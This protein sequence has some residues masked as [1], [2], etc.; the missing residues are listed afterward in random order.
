[1]PASLSSFISGNNY[2]R[3]AI[4]GTFVAGMKVGTGYVAPTFTNT[5]ASNNP[6][7]LFGWLIYAR[8]NTAYYNPAK[9]TTAD[10][11]ILYS[12][13][14]D[15]VGDLNKLSGITNCL[16]LDSTTAS[17][18]T[19]FFINTDSSTVTA[20]QNGIDFLYALNYL[21]YGGQL[22]LAP[23]VTGFDT[24]QSNTGTY[25][26]VVIDKDID[27][28]VANWL[29]TQ[30]YTI[31]IYPTVAVAGV[32]GEGLTL[33]SFDSAPISWS[34][35]DITGNAGKRI[36]GVYGTKT[37]STSDENFDISSL[38]SNGKF[39][40]TLNTT[41]DVAGFFARAKGRNE[42]Y[43]T[44]AGMDRSMPLNGSINNTVDWSSTTRTELK[45]KRVNFFVN[46][47]PRFLGSDLV[48]ATLNTSIT[49]NDRVGPARMRSALTNKLNEIGLKYSFEINNAS[50]R[51]AVNSEIQTALEQ[52]SSYIDTTRT[53]IICDSSNNTDNSSELKISVIVKPLLSVDSFVIDLTFTQ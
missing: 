19:G 17:G 45:T 47:S 31:G 3:E 7:G 11:Y 40:Y 27:S 26:D 36:F 38:L 41:A 49:V 8:S 39:A 22:L 33:P 37:K 2:T 5:G 18:N 21:A 44:V 50:T 20:T 34:S 46:Y 14:G 16:L 15:F 24:Y 52:Y 35:T 42:Q 10:K 6:G 23:F 13:P 30:S 4:T 1:M 53:Q 29:K 43:L 32:T 28:S 12:N 9:G 25:L 48:G 51:D